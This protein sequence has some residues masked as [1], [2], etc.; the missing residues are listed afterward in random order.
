MGLKQSIVVVN[1]YTVPTPGGGSRGGTPGAYVT[2]YM[3]RERATETLAPIRRH[4]MQEFISRYMARESAVQV[5]DVPD[6][7][8]LKRSM[9]AAQGNGGVAFG[10]GD[11]SLSHDQLEA[12]S[13]DVQRLFDEG[14]TVMKTVI[15]FDEEYLRAHGLV[16]PGFRCT[17][18]G[19]YRGQLDQMKLR[20]ALMAGL[21]RMGS[22]YYDELRYVAVIQVDTEHVH[23]HLAMVDAGTGTLAPDG[24]QR[25][26]ISERSKSVL[27]RGTDAYLDSKSHVAHL[28]SAVGYERR[29]VSAY[30]KKWAH[31][32]ML[33]EAL[34]QF[35]LAALPADRRMWR[36]TT[37]HQGMA[38]PNRIVRELV[39]EV[40]ARPESPMA[41]A[42]ASIRDYA[43]QRAQAEGLGAK[44]RAALIET[45]RERIMERGVNAVYSLLRSLPLESLAVRT[46]VMDAM[47]MDYQEMAA[48]AGVQ[49]DAQDDLL[50]FGFRLR[51]YSMRLEQH[52]A[53]RESNHGKARGWEA[54]DAAGAAAIGSRVLYEFWLA[55]E[56]Y[57]ARVAAKYRKFLA[58]VPGTDDWYRSWQSVAGYGERVLSLE[59]MRGDDSLRRMSDLDEAERIG[60]Q[61]YGQ[62]GG[63]LVAL[64]DEAS[65]DALAAR[66]AAM[67][68]RYAVL[69][70]DLRVE[71][72]GR[73]LVLQ[74]EQDEHGADIPAITAGAEF[75]FEEVKGLDLHRMRYDFSS[76]VEVGPFA[77]ASFIEAARARGEA[78]AKAVAYLEGSG[79]GE[80]VAGLPVGDIVMMNRAASALV[81]APGGSSTL[82]SEV[83]AMGA[84]PSSLPRSRTTSLARRLSAQVAAGVDRAVAAS[85]DAVVDPALE[86]SPG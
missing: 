75:P 23:C 4:R 81:V 1:E 35:L 74:T 37:N 49:E 86:Q 54:A 66:S 22:T 39:T 60:R 20:L 5:L 34:P 31:Q 36:S 52:T 43:Q 13:T 11:V 62:S 41:G 61:V 51:S 25:G 55:E 58:L 44:E 15:S 73:G 84:M 65:L 59:S 53:E 77:T 72:A 80:E 68:E 14:H 28:S 19:D 57:H 71:L 2:R 32:Q 12:A 38:K 30:V 85:E 26:K 47:G 78:L 3:A 76:D 70:A 29:N 48:R 9:A 46:E 33:R 64:G 50:G 7:R 56:E 83:A 17:N 16:P 79:Q 27:R 10:Y 8:T 18:R 40:L 67:R 42:M 82:C 6:R 24:T 63:H 69:V 21:E 45:G